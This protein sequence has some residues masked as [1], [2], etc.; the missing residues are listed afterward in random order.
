MRTTE[1]QE[2]TTETGERPEDGAAGDGTT[3]GRRARGERSR[4][5]II[6]A[7]IDLMRSGNMHPGAADVAQSSGVSLRTVFRHFDDIDSLYREMAQVI[8]SE[9]RPQTNAP[10]EAD[11]WRGRMDEM[12]TRRAAIY[13]H[14]MPLKVGADLRRFQSSFLADD[15]ARF[16]ELERAALAAILPAAV[17]ND[18]ITLAALD[19]SLSF[20]S[21]RRLRQDMGLDAA[22]TEAVLR[23]SVNRLLEGL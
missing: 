3:D 19:M 11:T 21:W 8:E 23:H 12:I 14:I 17:K 4:Q 22:K 18:P 5:R 20:T 10:F 6:E 7:I 1:A 15:H 16:C 2:V 9:V 13:E